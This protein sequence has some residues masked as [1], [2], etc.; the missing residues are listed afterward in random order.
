MVINLYNKYSE[1]KNINIE[2]D[3]LKIISDIEKGIDKEISISLI[4]VDKEEIH[5][6]NKEY[7]G[8]DRP[9]DVISFCLEDEED[10]TYIGDIFVCIEKV[11]EQ[12]E[13][14]SHS[15]EREFAFLIIHGILHLLGYDHINKD[16][17]AIMFEKQKELLKKIGYERK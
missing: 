16:D 7:R 9:T 2:F 13:E 8:I 17:E 11:Y 5:Q 4:L 15:K 14:Y 10:S 1:E 12:S 6:I 3:Y